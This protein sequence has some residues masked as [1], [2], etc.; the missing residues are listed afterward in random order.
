MRVGLCFIERKETADVPQ[1]YGTPSSWT[2][3]SEEDNISAFDVKGTKVTK[4]QCMKIC[5][6]DNLCTGFQFPVN[7]DE[8]FKDVCYIFYESG[9][10]T[11]LNEEGWG[12]T[13]V[14]CYEKER[15]QGYSPM[16]P[17]VEAEDAG[18]GFCRHSDGTDIMPKWIMNVENVDIC[19][20]MCVATK[21]CAGYNFSNDE[22]RLWRA[23]GLVVGG[24]STNDHCMVVRQTDGDFSVTRGYCRIVWD[25]EDTLKGAGRPFGR[26]WSKDIYG[27]SDY[28]D[29]ATLTECKEHCLEDPQCVAFTGHYENG[30]PGECFIHYEDGDYIPGS[31]AGKVKCYKHRKKVRTP[32][33]EVVGKGICVGSKDKELKLINYRGGEEDASAAHLNCQ[34]QCSKVANCE[35]FSVE[36]KRGAN[37]FVYLEP[38]VAAKLVDEDPDHIDDEATCMR[39]VQ[40]NL[41]SVEVA[42]SGF[43]NYLVGGGAVMTLAVVGALMASFGRKVEVKDEVNPLLAA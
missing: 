22:C 36:I 25:E 35:G 16:P 9:P 27:P 8:K 29:T 23:D 18:R 30:N 32:L 40:R 38:P 2:Y 13:D 3:V 19:N 39:K 41:R 7:S 17:K 26:R 14:E 42:D 43:H 34:R 12:R 4:K 1:R 6:K 5:D 11:V 20:R 31:N 15:G 10:F 28:M 24:T 37:C 33:F 21:G